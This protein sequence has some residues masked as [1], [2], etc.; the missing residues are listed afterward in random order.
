MSA[1]TGYAC[2]ILVSV[3]NT[4]ETARMDT[5]AGEVT[6][7]LQSWGS[8]DRSVEPQLF[9]LV[10]PDLKNLA[11]GMMRRE[12]PGHSLQPTA[13]LNEA[14]C[15]L[16]AARKRDWHNRRHFFAF[17]ARVMRRLLI[18]H[19]RIGVTFYSTRKPA[20]AKQQAIA[21]DQHDQFIAH[22]EAGEADKAAD[23]AVAHWELS[24]LQIESFVT[25]ESIQMPLGK[26]P[27]GIE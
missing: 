24:R 12:R 23:L 26:P 19:T 14:Y 17:A 4:L 6:E 20:F 27:G 13:L 7:L 22:I 15:R 5:P 1:I 16:V 18:D 10:L 8:G 25:P 3:H 9:E 21:A 11:R 2:A